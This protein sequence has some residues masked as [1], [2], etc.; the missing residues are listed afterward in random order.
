MTDK[1]KSYGIFELKITDNNGKIVDYI[2]KSNSIRSEF[3][4]LVAQTLAGVSGK[5]CPYITSIY[6][7]DTSGNS[8][9]S[10]SYSTRG[11]VTGSNYNGATAVFEDTS[12][13]SYTV[14]SAILRGEYMSGGSPIGTSIAQATGLNKSKGS[15]QTL[16]ATWT[17]YLPY[18]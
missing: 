8:I 13:D 7:Y 16:T 10:L 17:I 14:G 9:K 15:T 5:A 6:L 2:R 3:T 12:S 11:T 18:G 1:L 4:S